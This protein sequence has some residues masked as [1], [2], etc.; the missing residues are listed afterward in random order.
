LV[1]LCPPT[2]IVEVFTPVLG[3]E[4]DIRLGAF[5]V[6]PDLTQNSSVD[7]AH[8]LLAKNVE[9]MGLYGE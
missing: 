3:V 8:E 2:H 9:A 4:I 5:R 1:L 7:C 6:D